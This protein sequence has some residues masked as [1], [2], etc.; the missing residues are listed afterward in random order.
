MITNNKYKM[1]IIIKVNVIF[2]K[3]NIKN[4]GFATFLVMLLD[5]KTFFS[6][7]NVLT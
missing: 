5:N 7:L 3:D 1:K 2:K 4:D 6:D